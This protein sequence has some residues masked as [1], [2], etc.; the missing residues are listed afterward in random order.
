MNTIVEVAADAAE[1]KKFAVT[2]TYN[3]VTR[4]VDANFNETVHALL[5]R[6]LQVFGSLPAQHT[7]SLY[8]EG[9]NE[10]EEKAHVGEVGIKPGT[11]L[12]LRPGKVKGGLA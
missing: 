3:G 6:A 5:Q 10:L 7:L 9:G 2:I 11:R 8:D 12:L 1:R 4:S